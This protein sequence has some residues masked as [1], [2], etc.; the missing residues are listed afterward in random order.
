MVSRSQPARMRSSMLGD[1]RQARSWQ[2]FGYLVGGALVLVGL[3]HLAALL[4]LRN[5]DPAAA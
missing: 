2:R 1:W 4:A 5:P 3:A